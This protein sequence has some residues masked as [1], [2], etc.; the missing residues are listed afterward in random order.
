MAVKYLE[1]RMELLR[2]EY[3]LIQAWKKTAA[4]IRYHNSFADTLALD[5]AA[6][7]LPEFLGNL[8]DRL[9]SSNTWKNDPLRLVLAPKSQNWQATKEHWKPKK[10]KC[11]PKK[12]IDLT[13]LRPLGHVSLEDQV[14]ATAL[15]L[16]LA[17]RIETR[18]GDPREEIGDLKSRKKVVSYGN[19]L[20]CDRISGALRHRWG[21]SKLYRAYFQDYRTFISR[22]KTTIQSISQVGDKDFF[23]V[24]TDLEKFYDRVR[25][26]LL[27]EATKQI[28]HSDDDPEF[29]PFLGTVFNWNWDPRD[30]NGARKYAEDSKIDYFT[31][32]ALPQGLVASGF[33]A[34]L[35][36]LSFDNELRGKI[37]EEFL[38]GILLVDVCR[39]VDD[40]RLV[41][42]VDQDSYDSPDDL[43][44]EI[45]SWL[46]QKL[47]KTAPGLKLSEEKT[48]ILELGGE[49]PHL[50]PQS[51]KMKRIQTAISGG[52]DAQGGVEILDAILG[53][54]RTQ[55]ELKLGDNDHLSLTP[56]VRDVTVARFA[57]RRYRN[58]FRSTRPLLPEKGGATLQTSLPESRGRI[59]LD[60]DAKS[61][62]F[63]LIQRWLNDPSNVLLMRIG[64]DLW[65]DAKVLKYILSLLRPFT[66][67]DSIPVEQRQIAWY[68][69]S[70]I[71]RAGATETGLVPEKESLP[72]GVCLKSYRTVLQEEAVFYANLPEPIIPWYLRQQALLFLATCTSGEIL[73]ELQ[74]ENAGEVFCSKKYVVTDPEQEPEG[75]HRYC[76]LIRFLSHDDPDFS[77]SEF[78]TYAVLARHAFLGHDA[79]LNLV[80]NRLN[81]ARVKAIAERDPS[82]FLELLDA[83]IISE[84]TRDL[85]M[86]IR[87]DLCLDSRN[88]KGNTLAHEILNQSSLRNEFR[89]ELSLLYFANALL[90]KW[91]LLESKPKVIRPEQITLN[92]KN[93]TDNRIKGV[94]SQELNIKTEDDISDSIYCPP[95]WCSDEDRW[96]IQLGFLLRFILSRHPDFTRHARPTHWSESESAYRPIRSH[97]YLRLY[98]LY[99]GQPAFGDDWLPI[100]DW[101]EKFLLALLAWPGCSTPEEFGWVKQ[102]INSTRTRIQERI[103]SLN[104]RRGAASRTL[105]MPLN[106]RQY[107]RKN[108]KPALRACIVQTVF[109]SDD[110][111]K[112]DDLALNNPESRRIHRNHLSAALAAV[113]RMLVLRNTHENSKE[114]LDWLILPELAVHRD[115]IRTHLIPFARAHKAIILTGL[116]YEEISKG[117]PLV[118]SALWIIPEQSEAHGLQIRTRRQGKCH[119]TKKELAFNEG[120]ELVQG[121]RPC[122]W[123]IEYPWSS[124]PDVDPLRLTAAVCYDATD[125]TLV[126][127]LKNQSDVFAIPALNKDVGTFDKMAIALHY[128]MFQ[129]VIVANNGF[130]GG[131][132]AYFPHKKPY[133]RQ[134][135]HT[136]GQPQATISFV[137]VD[138]I[139]TFQKRM[140]I[141]NE[142]NRIINDFKSPPA[143]S[144]KGRSEFAL[145]LFT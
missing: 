121:F 115:D 81:K 87:K 66:E 114:H 60:Q 44:D 51:Q 40:L 86:R 105:I 58:T 9:E 12:D 22:P 143:G 124:N 37:G 75:T 27:L 110:E 61:F 65:P 130:Y 28:Q 43:R 2:E 4:Y 134:V 111:F 25:P 77:D 21:S 32:V 56:D 70:E 84:I 125:L 45:F 5:R 30:E 72:S 123:L 113:K 90:E 6:A 74:T 55:K 132:N 79:T 131:S 126:A 35:V 34:N 3:V 48:K 69:L 102:G 96:R 83:G 49:S 141:D 88:P 145:R 109:P 17:D 50:L 42:A 140:A 36:L 63:D 122:Q 89:N 137:D 33:F 97:R 91:L 19:R 29:F 41:I 73:E 24:D 71:F 68:C 80:R 76:E 62:G 14:V 127:D 118:N 107:T 54:L 92:S 106:V 7:N 120:E 101:F 138:D 136:H 117:E 129:Y 39:Y 26:K 64:L 119:L 13:A 10:E 1:P 99:N 53:M 16:C 8:R 94:E 142:G 59:E 23:V 108:N 78:A 112:R 52:F 18:Q 128:H 46:E 20:F 67:N 139:A 85:P 31:Q 93:N 57:A 15:M 104:K 11:K 95:Y 82:F 100:T 38:D 135:F 47:A 116:T 98:G 103:D 144:S 133:T